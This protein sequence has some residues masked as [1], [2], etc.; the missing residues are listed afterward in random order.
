MLLLIA[1][2]VWSIIYYT[3]ALL[4]FFRLYHCML[5]LVFLSLDLY[6]EMC[7]VHASLFLLS[8]IS[9]SL[10]ALIYSICLENIAYYLKNRNHFHCFNLHTRTH[11]F[12]YIRISHS[13]YGNWLTVS[14]PAAS[15]MFIARNCS[16]IPPPLF[17]ST[18]FL[19]HCSYLDIRYYYLNML[20]DFIIYQTRVCVH[21]FVV[22][23][24]VVL[25]ICIIYIHS[26]ISLHQT[27]KI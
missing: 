14:Y 16:S 21:S 22:F 5:L 6:E 20:V 15:I 27:N 12:I 17:Y 19:L 7:I 10:Y 18:V 1:I 2:R 3:R 11:T 24:I 8:H 26:A 23:F 9:I 4:F 13:E 25:C